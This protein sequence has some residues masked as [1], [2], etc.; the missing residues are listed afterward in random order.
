MKMSRSRIYLTPKVK[1]KLDAY[2]KLCAYEISGLGK[3]ERLGNED[4]LVTEVILLEQACSPASTLLD[5]DDLARFMTELLRKGENPA[6]WK[7]W[8]HSHPGDSDVFW[9]YTD[10]KT[11]ASFNN[12]WMLSIVANGQGDYLGRIDVYEPV[13]LY[14]D[15]VSVSVYTELDDEELKAIREEIERK[16][17]PK[18][19]Y[20][21]QYKSEEQGQEEDEGYGLPEAGWHRYP[22]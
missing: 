4:F 9:S 1:A 5:E 8:F 15:E 20:L 17:R 19:Y 6:K 12:G 3:V 2:I 16:V 7:L 21:K 18:F 11:C 22:R 10:E 14:D 13:H